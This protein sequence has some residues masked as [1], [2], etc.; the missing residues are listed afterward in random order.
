[1]RAVTFLELDFDGS[2][3]DMIVLADYI[4]G[5]GLTGSEPFTVATVYLNQGS[6]FYD[7]HLSESLF[8]RTRRA[9]LG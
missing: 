1:M 9:N 5:V 2:E 6:Y 3:P 4:T 8:N 7:R